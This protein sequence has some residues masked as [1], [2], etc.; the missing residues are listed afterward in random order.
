MRR[1]PKHSHQYTTKYRYMRVVEYNFTSTTKERLV[2]I[3]FFRSKQLCLKAYERVLTKDQRKCHRG[4]VGRNF[5]SFNKGLIEV[6][7]IEKQDGSNQRLRFVH[8]VH[9]SVRLK[10]QCHHATFRN[11]CRNL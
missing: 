2:D 7:V 8:A 1:T 4:I 10:L 11:S 9:C 3:Q 6:D 5:C